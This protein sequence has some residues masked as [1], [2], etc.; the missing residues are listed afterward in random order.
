MATSWLESY[1]WHSLIWSDDHFVYYVIPTSHVY[2]TMVFCLVKKF[3]KLNYTFFLR[4]KEW[5]FD[6]GK[7]T[8]VVAFMVIPGIFFLKKCIHIIFVSFWRSSYQKYY[9]TSFFFE[10]IFFF[11]TDS[12]IRS[13]TDA[14]SRPVMNCIIIKKQ[15]NLLE[16]L[17]ALPLFWCNNLLHFQNV[18]FLHFYGIHKKNIFT[19]KQDNFRRLV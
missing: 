18:T 9:F 5:W 17:C 8:L 6:W 10:N 7:C 3:V 16:F 11:N 14:S 4:F 13:L 2:A 15:V 19:E 1:A 12:I